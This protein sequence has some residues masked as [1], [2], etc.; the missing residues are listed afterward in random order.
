[1]ECPRDCRNGK[2]SVSPALA[3]HRKPFVEI[4]RRLAE[5]LVNRRDASPGRRVR[6]LLTP[7]SDLFVFFDL[8]ELFLVTASDDFLKRRVTSF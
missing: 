7:R 5:M 6:R 1:M 8:D 3:S 4:R 2:R